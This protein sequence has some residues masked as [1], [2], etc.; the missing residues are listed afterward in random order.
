MYSK[1]RRNVILISIDINSTLFSAI[2]LN[3]WK[4]YRKKDYSVLLVGDI[5]SDYRYK[6]FL[7]CNFSSR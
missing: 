6:F 5:I 1:E 2:I 3:F 4:L 7:K